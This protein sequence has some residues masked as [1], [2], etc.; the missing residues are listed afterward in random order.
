MRSTAVLRTSDSAIFLLFDSL[1]SPV[2][3]YFSHAHRRAC[4]NDNISTIFLPALTYLSRWESCVVKHGWCGA[5]RVGVRVSV[6]TS[7][8]AQV[9]GA[10][11]RGG[12][13]M[14]GSGWGWRAGWYWESDVLVPGPVVR[15]GLSVGVLGKL[16]HLGQSMVQLAK[17]YEERST[18]ASFYFSKKVLSLKLCNH[19]MLA[20]NVLLL[21]T[22]RSKGSL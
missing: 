4:T 13:T 6:S 11:G 12:P 9:W 1:T 7:L 5:S 17:K 10:L 15:R 16:V 22:R 18:A 3:K 21:P 20:K 2:H 14:D 8:L 19:L